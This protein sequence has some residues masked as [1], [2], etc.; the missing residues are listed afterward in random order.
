MEGF[1]HPIG[2]GQSAIDGLPAERDVRLEFGYDEQ[3]RRVE[4]TVRDRFSGMLKKRERF[5][6]QGWNLVAT[7]DA[8]DLNNI[9]VV[10]QYFWRTGSAETGS[11]GLL[12]IAGD[13][14]GNPSTARRAYYTGY[15]GRGNLTSLAGLTRGVAAAAFEYS[16]FGERLRTEGTEQ[17]PDLDALGAHFGFA[18]QYTDRE[19]GLV[20][21]GHRYYHP[22][23]GR[24][25]NRDPL[26][27]AGGLNRYLYANNDPI[28]FT[29]YRG[30]CTA[31]PGGG[32]LWGSIM[33]NIGRAVGGV[34][35]G[36]FD[37][38]ANVV[39]GASF[40]LDGIGS[41]FDFVGLDFVG[42]L[43]HTAANIGHAIGRGLGAVSDVFDGG[44]G[45]F[46]RAFGGAL[47]PNGA[48]SIWGGKGSLA[49]LFSPG[50]GGGA[51]KPPVDVPPERLLEDLRKLSCE[52]RRK[53]VE[54][55]KLSTEPIPEDPKLFREYAMFVGSDYETAGGVVFPGPPVVIM[56]SDGEFMKGP[57]RPLNAGNFVKLEESV[58]KGK[59]VAYYVH[60][61]MRDEPPSWIS[62]NGKPAG[63]YP[64]HQSGQLRNAESL[65]IAIP[66]SY[67][68]GDQHSSPS[69]GNYVK[70]L[71][72]DFLDK[73]MEGCD[74][75]GKK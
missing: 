21:F 59:Y 16:P 15:D 73:L 4:K 64:V 18:T 56:G 20:Y 39:H 63:D 66:H 71:T 58:I 7:L 6:Y 5:L 74:E 51:E 33:G 23:L 54:I 72:A 48:N 14:D 57:A 70:F 60:T 1:H 19:T 45:L 32:G 8:T 25:L 52:D 61:H 10:S 50:S 40:V 27:E 3:N 17:L 69:E 43:F 22:D 35:G 11:F 26:G 13:H 44:N 9:Q 67:L 30:L 75:D 28:N 34:I 49:S 41:A 65:V 68:V 38:A 2:P 37:A 47:D 62:A 55:A 36:V 53:F 42:D 29:D 31:D 46:D 24:F 12:M